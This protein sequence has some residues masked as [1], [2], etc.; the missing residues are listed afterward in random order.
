MFY[1]FLM[2]LDSFGISECSNPQ[3]ISSFGHSTPFT[4]G[5]ISH[6]R[7]GNTIGGS[8]TVDILHVLVYASLLHTYM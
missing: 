8:Q 3:T 1:H 2:L 7:F 4:C 5:K 6:K